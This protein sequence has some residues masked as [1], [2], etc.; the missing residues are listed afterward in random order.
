M[1]ED[2]KRDNTDQGVP[3]GGDQA[4]KILREMNEFSADAEDLYRKA[5]KGFRSV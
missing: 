3:V 2:F 1:L 4:M 5:G